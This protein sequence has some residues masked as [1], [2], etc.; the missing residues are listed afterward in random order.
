MFDGIMPPRARA[1]NSPES[2]AGASLVM[3]PPSAGIL[4]V[5]AETSQFGIVDKRWQDIAP[6]IVTIGFPTGGI[7]P[8]SSYPPFPKFSSAAPSSAFQCGLLD[9][10]GVA[11]GALLPGVRARA[12]LVLEYGI[13]SAGQKVYMD[14][15]P[16]AYQVPPCEWARASILLWGTDWNSLVQ[17]YAAA[18]SFATGRI[19]AHPPT[20][21][22][23]GIMFAGAGRSFAVPANARAF[24]VENISST[25]TP[26]I[27]IAGTFVSAVRNYATG[28]FVPGWSPLDS[29]IPGATVSITSDVDTSLR[30]TFYLAL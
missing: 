2:S 10:S 15:R 3:V 28:A 27:T 24:E 21:T 4:D 22:G 11:F 9:T 26:V 16:G 29:P 23:E 17:A 30:V 25:A 18:A 13:G 5:P 19:D 1:L 6:R 14:W 7:A 8:A 20:V 12:A